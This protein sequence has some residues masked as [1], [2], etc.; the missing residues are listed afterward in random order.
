VAEL[1][2]THVVSYW[3]LIILQQRRIRVHNLVY[4]NILVLR[5]RTEKTILFNNTKSSLRN[6]KFYSSYEH[7]QLKTVKVKQQRMSSKHGA[8]QKPLSLHKL[9]L[10]NRGKTMKSSKTRAAMLPFLICTLAIS[11]LSVFTRSDP[12]CVLVRFPWPL[13]SCC[14]SAQGQS[15]CQQHLL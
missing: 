11:C 4:T 6:F 15:Q 13:P 10:I 7:Y 2:C 12:Q 3:R 1:S 9:R 8:P 14:H 5:D